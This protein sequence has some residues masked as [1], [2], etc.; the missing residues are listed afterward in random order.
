MWIRDARRRLGSRLEHGWARSVW[1]VARRVM[2]DARD[3]RV[4]GLA[5]EV[6][7]F[8]LISIP[9]LLL[10]LGG[11]LGFVADV[12]GAAS[13]RSMR[14]AILDGA[15]TVFDDST[16]RETVRPALDNL[17]ATGRADIMSLGAILALWSSSRATKAA[18][19]A[20]TLA[21][22]VAPSRSMWRRR[23]LAIGLTAGAVTSAVIVLPL[24]V[25][26]PGLLEQGFRA[27]EFGAAAAPLAIVVHWAVIGGIAVVLL[28]TF[29]HLAPPHWTPWRRDLPGALLA[30]GLWIIGAVVLRAYVSWSITSDSTYGPLAAPIVLLL[31]LY[32][33]SLALLLG[34][35][36]NGELEKMGPAGHEPRDQSEPRRSVGG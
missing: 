32:M 23:V 21:Y 31:W 18:V 4:S 28:T 9:P 15:R 8:A 12:I 17:L 10:V 35:E 30:L 5:A 33:T 36:L 6:T 2:V 14:A 25:I 13:T 34:A 3:D 11:G 27:L 26:G 24:L 22:D 1:I 29:Y 16:V 19:V 20:T 7:F